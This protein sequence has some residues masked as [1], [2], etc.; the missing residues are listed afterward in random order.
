MVVRN[1][2]Y[3]AHNRRFSRH[4]SL[5]NRQHNRNRRIPLPLYIFP[6]LFQSIG[7]ST[8]LPIILVRCNSNRL[9][10]HLH[11]D[12]ALLDHGPTQ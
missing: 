5:S 6:E 2:L 10:P 8:Q 9:S 4:W 1:H 11:R 7:E 3:N 12:N